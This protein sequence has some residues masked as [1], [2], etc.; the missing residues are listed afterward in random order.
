MPKVFTG[1]VRIRRKR[2]ARVLH[3][4][5]RVQGPLR[6]SAVTSAVAS[7]FDRFHAC[8]D[9]AREKAPQLSGRVEL[10]FDVGTDGR[11]AAASAGNS[12]LADLELDRCLVASV[13][14]LTLPAIEAGIS[15]VT[16]PLFFE[17]GSGDSAKVRVG[18]QGAAARAAAQLLLTLT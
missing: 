10:R 14:D 1:Q 18:A 15:S 13:G 12:S 4:G 16:Y 5:L 17:P 7:R 3:T 11:V 2:A 6:P 8:Y 9:R